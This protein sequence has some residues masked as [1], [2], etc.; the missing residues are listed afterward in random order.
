M[1]VRFDVYTKE[2]RNIL[3]RAADELDRLGEAMARQVS[4]AVVSAV[5]PEPEF[6]QEVQ[7]EFIGEPVEGFIALFRS[8]AQRIG[9]VAASKILREQFGVNRATELATEQQAALLAA[10]ATTPSV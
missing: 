1:E 2:E 10:M 4:A 9:L 8:E 3:M 7:A 5:I 6:R